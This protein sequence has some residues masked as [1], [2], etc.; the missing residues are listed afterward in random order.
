MNNLVLKDTLQLC[1]YGLF[2]LRILHM[3]AAMRIKW[4]SKRILIGKT[5]LYAAYRRVYANSQ[6]ASTCI[7]IVEKLV[8]LCLS[9]PYRTTPTPVDYTTISETA[10][11]IG[12]DFLADTS[13]DATNLQFTHRNLLPREDYLPALEQLVKTDALAVNIKV[14]EFSMYGF[15]DDISTITI[16]NPCWLERVNNVA[17]LIIHIIFRPWNYDKIL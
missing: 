14:K 8:F 11:Y 6:I 2:L 1:F 9:L 16:D 17:L 5:D 13:W 4:P 15:I 12:N 3:I 7:T 10:I